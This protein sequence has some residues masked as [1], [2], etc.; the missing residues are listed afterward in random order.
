MLLD[1]IYSMMDSLNWSLIEVTFSHVIELMLNFTIKPFEVLS[2]VIYSFV[3]QIS[4]YRQVVFSFNPAYELA[5]CFIFVSES[6]Y[7]LNIY[8]TV[9]HCL[10]RNLIALVQRFAL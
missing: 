3:K 9:G 1:S 6:L 10:R 4:W 2:T 8:V 5:Y 7:V